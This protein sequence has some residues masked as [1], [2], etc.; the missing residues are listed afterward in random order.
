MN[1]TEKDLF[2]PIVNRDLR[3]AYPELAKIEEFKPIRSLDVKFCWYYAI[4]F[5]D[6]TPETERIQQAINHSYRSEI[7]PADLDRFLKG[8]FSDSIKAAI[9]KFE[10][11]DIG[12]RI[13]AK[14]TAERTLAAFEKLAGTNVDTV[15]VVKI[16]LSLDQQSAEKGGDEPIG[17]KRDWNQVNAYV[18]SM[19][20]INESLPGLVSVVEQGFGVSTKRQDTVTGNIRD[21]HQRIKEEQQTLKNK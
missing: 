10:S 3:I 15:G 19:V 6:I 17:E 21:D 4:Y 16:Y 11:F 14:F 2:V 1:I 13:R 18:N 12:S 20:K 8:N 5:A 7:K 9:K